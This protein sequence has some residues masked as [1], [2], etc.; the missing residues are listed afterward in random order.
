MCGIIGICGTKPVAE[1]L[2]KGLRVL[3]YRGYDSAGIAISGPGQVERLRAKSKI[4]GLE[5]KHQKS[6]LNGNCGIAHTRWATHGI[7][8]EVNAHPHSAGK[9]TLVHN[10][11]IENFGEI[12]QKLLNK[13]RN[14][15]TDTDT[16][17]IAHLIDENLKSGLEP[18]AAVQ[19]S[20]SQLTGAYSLAIL[21]DDHPNLVIGARQGSPLVVGKS[22][23]ETYLGSDALALTDLSTQIAYLEEGD[24]VMLSPNDVQFFDS[25]GEAVNREF[26]AMPVTGA[27]V[28][29]GSFPHFMLKEIHEQAEVIF[30]T[31]SEYVDPL[32]YRAKPRDDLD[33]SKFDRIIFLAC[34]TA[35]YAAMHAKY[36]LEKLAKIPVDVEL[37]SEFRYRKPALNKNTL[38]IGVSQSGETADTLEALRLF[39][40]KSCVTAAVVNVLT[41]SLAR[42]CDHI[43]PIHAGPEIGVASTKAFT[44]QLAALAG[45]ALLGATQRNSCS[46]KEI[47]AY[48]ED[49]IETPHLMRETLSRQH[50]LDAAATKIA[51]ARNCIYIGRGLSA[52]LA[53]EGALKLKE[54]TYI[55]AEGYPAGE[56]KHGPIALIEPGLP[57]VA[58]MPSDSL[59]DKTLSNVNNILS[60]N[61]EVIAMTDREGVRRLKDTNIEHIIQLPKTN[62]L[63]SSMIFALPL[64]L[65]AYKVAVLKGTDVDQPRNLAKSVTVE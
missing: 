6:G 52:A 19:A 11:I 58:V 5:A 41:S 42:E 40:Q 4:N 37:A 33:L 64:Q 16:E 30:H 38:G 44:C 23:T 12:R 34:G 17:V 53:L 55:H 48:C 49:L 13:G 45:L 3:E 61:G 57:T 65:L 2:I 35:Y 7:A 47:K 27:M 60:R 36:W 18:V 22:E 25:H 46:E 56:L 15:A 29:K 43:F 9:V 50:Q 32:N 62:Y 10:G 1:R 28:G 20:L 63:N 51:A 21:F 14:F 59:F 39:K 54:L 24:L 8:N 26:Q 31:I